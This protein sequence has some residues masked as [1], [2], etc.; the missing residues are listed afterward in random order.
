M[1]NILDYDFQYC[2]NPFDDT[3]MMDINQG[4]GVNSENGKGISGTQFVKEITMLDSMGKKA[5]DIYINSQGGSVLDGYSI[6]TAIYRCKTPTNGYVGGAAASTAGWILQACDNRYMFSFSNYMIHN[7]AYKGIDNDGQIDPFLELIKDG[8]MDMLKTK[9]LT[10]TALNKMMD[11]ETYLGPKQA[12]EYGFIDEILDINADVEVGN[13]QYIQNINLSEM[14]NIVEKYSLLENKIKDN[15]KNKKNIIKMDSKINQLKKALNLSE[16]A[17]EVEIF[18]AAKD[19]YPW[20]FKFAEQIFNE[21]T[22]T[23]VKGKTGVKNDSKEMTLKMENEMEEDC[24]NDMDEDDD[25]SVIDSAE[26]IKKNPMI[27]NKL[28]KEIAN[29]KK[30]IAMLKNLKVVELVNAAEKD[31]RISNIEVPHYIKLGNLNYDSTEIILNS[32]KV[33]RKT[34]PL[35]NVIDK[36][37]TAEA[38]VS[39]KAEQKELVNTELSQVVNENKGWDTLDYNQLFGK[40]YTSMD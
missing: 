34:E 27:D 25:D 10:E 23:A 8:L 7:P 1:K 30:E 18:N 28:R 20:M 17:T 19:E 35:T 16:T 31:G 21:P 2:A 29:L 9:N 32:I 15:I 22:S 13:I 24:M 40:K 26:G 6:F 12:L 38:I 36:V 4:I 14:V 11:A 37:A 33:S 39:I 5:I 3:P